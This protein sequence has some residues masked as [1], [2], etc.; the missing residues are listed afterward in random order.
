MFGNVKLNEFIG[1]NI[2]CFDTETT[3]FPI[4]IKNENGKRSYY[5]PTNNDKYN[6]SRIVQIAW[7]TINDF[8]IENIEKCQVRG[9][10]RKP[11]DFVINNND[12]STSIHKITNENAQQ[13]GYLLSDILN[14]KG[15]R[16]ALLECDYIM[17]HNILFDIHI[18]MNELHR[19]QHIKLYDKLKYV[20]D[21]DKY[22]CT[23][24][25]SQGLKSELNL[26]SLSL[27]NVYKFF[28]NDNKDGF[29][30]AEVDVCANLKIF[31]KIFEYVF[32]NKIMLDLYKIKQ[33]KKIIYLNASFKEKDIVKQMGAKYDCD[34]KKWYIYEGMKGFDK[35]I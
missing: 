12:Q 35:Y 18:L 22:L 11:L 5:C 26:K 2:L 14:N 31:K 19:M 8:S 27:L 3:G 30:N 6:E 29:H 7:T 21:K 33:N 16:K 9:Y 4:N 13:N 1:K 17:G 34:N 24:M 10:I 20:L 23:Y 15:L 25:M 32:D 28:Y